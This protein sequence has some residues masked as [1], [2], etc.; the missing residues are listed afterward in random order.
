[1]KIQLFACMLNVDGVVIVRVGLES[2]GLGYWPTLSEC[3]SK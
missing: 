3:L 2:V 1:M